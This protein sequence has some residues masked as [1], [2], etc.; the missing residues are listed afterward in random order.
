MKAKFL[1]LC[2][3]PLLLWNCESE[4]D[5]NEIF[6]GHT[7][8]ITGATVDGTSLTGDEIAALYTNT[9]SYYLTFSASTFSGVLVTGSIVNGTWS[10]DGGD[11]SISMTF[12]TATNAT[13][14]S[15]SSAIYNI[16]RQ[17]TS[18]SGDSNNLIIKQDSRNYVRFSSSK[19]L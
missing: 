15:L 3:L 11:H 10:A 8:F 7:W 2:L 18:Y 6:N 14:T 1:L 16:L 4:D 9:S 5:V 12:A 19:A 13:A 17:A